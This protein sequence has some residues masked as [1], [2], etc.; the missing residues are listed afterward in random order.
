MLLLKSQ[1]TSESVLGA[2]DTFYWRS[3][4]WHVHGS[5][6]H[7]YHEERIQSVSHTSDVLSKLSRRWH[8]V[9]LRVLITGLFDLRLSWHNTYLTCVL[10]SWGNNHRITS[11]SALLNFML[12]PWLKRE[13]CQQGVTLHTLSSSPWE[14]EVGGLCKLK[15]GLDYN[16]T[17]C[18]AGAWLCKP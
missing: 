13:T 4:S 2:G 8:I 3:T 17:P 7:S 10:V 12:H 5:G 9:P 14:A 6:F 11:S 1:V 18:H 16:V 15:A